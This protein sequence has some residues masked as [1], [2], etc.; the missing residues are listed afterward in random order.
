VAAAFRRKILKDE[1]AVRALVG[2]KHIVCS[3]MQ[4]MSSV[5]DYEMKV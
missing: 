2:V 3:E 4:E 1:A 5:F